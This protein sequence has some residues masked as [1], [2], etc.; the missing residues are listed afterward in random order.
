MESSGPLFHGSDYGNPKT[1]VA[2]FGIFVFCGGLPSQI[3]SFV[4]EL[5][6]VGRFSPKKLKSLIRA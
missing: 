6:L 5:F 3:N 4:P 1:A 2:T